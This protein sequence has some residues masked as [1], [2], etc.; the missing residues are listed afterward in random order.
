MLCQVRLSKIYVKFSK[1]ESRVKFGSAF[2]VLKIIDYC[3]IFT[4]AEKFNSERY[5]RNLLSDLAMSVGLNIGP[6]TVGPTR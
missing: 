4:F 1:N 3:L 2:F 6:S 5:K